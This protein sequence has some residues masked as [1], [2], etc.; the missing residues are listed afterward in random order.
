M[1]KQKSINYDFHL[2]YIFYRLNPL[3]PF[4]NVL[5]DAT[6]VSTLL[7]KPGDTVGE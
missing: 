4:R 7:I 6:W 3:P 5:P 2:C 1:T